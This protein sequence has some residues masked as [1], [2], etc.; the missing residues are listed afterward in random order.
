MRFGIM[1][2]VRGVAAIG[3]CILLG[4]LTGCGG[5]AAPA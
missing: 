5:G 4:M 3:A 2:K 1:N